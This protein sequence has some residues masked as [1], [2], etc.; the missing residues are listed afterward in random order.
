MTPKRKSPRIDHTPRL[1]NLASRCREAISEWTADGCEAED[2][3]VEIDGSFLYA[4]DLLAALDHIAPE[5]DVSR[6]DGLQ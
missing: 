3:E 4:T 1:L 2:A 5:L 6:R